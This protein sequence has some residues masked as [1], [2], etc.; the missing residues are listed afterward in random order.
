MQTNNIQ[1][2]TAEEK[3]GDAILAMLPR[4]AEF[5]LPETRNP[6]HLS[7]RQLVILIQH[8]IKKRGN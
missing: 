4:L 6:D 3:D 1:I 8:L 5:D 7:D 2:R